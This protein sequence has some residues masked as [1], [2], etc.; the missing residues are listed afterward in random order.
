MIFKESTLYCLRRTATRK[1]AAERAD[2]GGENIGSRIDRLS[3]YLLRRHIS[4]AADELTGASD[5]LIPDVSNSEVHDFHAAGLE[6]HDVAGFDVTMNNPVV[7][8]G[9]GQPLAHVANVI[10]LCQ[11]AERTASVNDGIEGLPFQILHHQIRAA[12]QV[13]QVVD[14]Y[15][16]GVLQIRR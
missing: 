2:A 14:S 6:H 15:D 8:G 11:H 7:V 9:I 1:S 12:I 5:G 10:D 13:S 3:I 16:V 4:Q